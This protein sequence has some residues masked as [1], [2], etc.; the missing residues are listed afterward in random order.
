MQTGADCFDDEHRPKHIKPYGYTHIRALA[1]FVVVLLRNVTHVGYGNSP[2][3][4]TTQLFAKE[5]IYLNK[6]NSTYK[7]Q[8]ALH[9]WLEGVDRMI[10]R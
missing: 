2:Y 3:W 6:I 4:G 8:F 1:D 10:L 5:P 9:H 7:A